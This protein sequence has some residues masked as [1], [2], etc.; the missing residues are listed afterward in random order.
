MAV[1]DDDDV[2]ARLLV[3]LPARGFEVACCR[4]GEEALLRIPHEEPD[5]VLTDH[6]MREIDGVELCERIV[7]TYP[8]IPV[9]LLTAF[10]SVETAVAAMRAGA[11]DFIVKPLDV[12]ALALSLERAIRQRRLH[13]EVHRLQQRSDRK[14]GFGGLVG[15]SPAMKQVFTFVEQTASLNASVLITGESGTGKELVARALHRKG[16]RPEGPFVAVNCAALP[17]ALLESELFGY[18]RGAFTGAQGPR[19]GL[20]A[21][22][23]GGTLFL[24]EIGEMPLVLQPKLLRVLQERK[25][26]PVGSDSES[27]FDTRVIAA[28]NCDLESAVRDGEFRTDLYFRLNVLGVQLPPLRARGTDVL[29]LAQVFVD[30][31]AVE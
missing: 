19:P 13:E 14:P 15:Q 16:R 10:G 20:L 17:E 25:V 9:I 27:T 18:A 3:T 29:L 23:S 5:V 4:T 7:T 12:G 28:T 31:F 21:S 24:D 11:F 22:S 2:L 26:R 30:Q 8:D 1:N 6:G